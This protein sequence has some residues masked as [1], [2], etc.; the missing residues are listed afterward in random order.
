MMPR[1]NSVGVFNDIS[2]AAFAVQHVSLDHAFASIIQGQ[3]KGASLCFRKAG[4][5]I[6][7]LYPALLT[8]RVGDG[9]SSLIPAMR[10]AFARVTGRFFALRTA[11][12]FAI[13]KGVCVAST[14][15]RAIAL[16]HFQLRFICACDWGF[17]IVR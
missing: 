9:H 14:L 4:S 6:V 13:A 1:A 11:D 5:T 16:Y 3:V 12:R 2:T 10:P 15:A 7:Y 8:H 17:F